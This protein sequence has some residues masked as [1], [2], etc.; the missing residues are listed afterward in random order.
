MKPGVELIY[1]SLTFV[2][3]IMVFIVMKY[4]ESDTPK[5]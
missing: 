1:G 2:V 3:M 4:S 5:K